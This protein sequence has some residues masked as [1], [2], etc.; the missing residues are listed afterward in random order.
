MTGAVTAWASFG[1]GLNEIAD[2]RSDTTAGKVNHSA[3]LSQVSRV[4]FL[5]FTGGTA[6]A[7]STTWA[8]D[9]AAP[10][11]VLAG[12]GL[13]VIYSV[14]PVRLKERGLAGIAGAATA[15]WTL[16]VLSISA[17]VPN[18]WM[19]PAALSFGFLGFAIGV[20]WMGV[21][22][23]ND[24]RGDRSAGI[25]TFATLGRPVFR[26]ILTAFAVELVLLAS[27]LV[28]AWPRSTDALA[29]LLIWMVLGTVLQNPVKG[30]QKRLKSYADAPLSG[31]YFI[32]LPAVMLLDRV[33][34]EI[35]RNRCLAS[36]SSRGGRSVLSNVL[37]S[38][39]ATRLKLAPS[40]RRALVP[41]RVPG[42]APDDRARWAQAGG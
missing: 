31:Y 12:L 29:T 30:W 1:Y 2:Y 4:M 17:A 41:A 11:L 6:F 42:S 34:S 39:A 24:L 18:G 7:L 23:M 26:L 38:C 14:P 15:Q 8:V 40:P 21:H 3:R 36:G 35:I 10:L 19:Q 28:L 16:P 13:T 20:R 33:V 27:F 9:T 32:A 22:Q 37:C 5:L 25:Q